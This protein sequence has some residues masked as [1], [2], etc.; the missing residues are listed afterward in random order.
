MFI[1]F[2]QI[3]FFLILTDFAF[4]C[5]YLFFVFGVLDGS[6]T[7]MEKAF[8]CVKSVLNLEGRFSLYLSWFLEFWCG[9]VDLPCV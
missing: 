4:F 2:P 9:G 5:N 6:Y 8:W 1:A 7:G 3:F